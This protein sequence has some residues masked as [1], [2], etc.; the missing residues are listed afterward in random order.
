M[1][2][3]YRKVLVIGATSGIG[4]ALATKLVE[5]DVPV[6]VSGRRKEKLD[7]FVQKY[8][9]DGKK[10]QAKAFDILRI[11]RVSCPVVRLY[12]GRSGVREHDK[13]DG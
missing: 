3:D 6:I 10:V 2:F 12:P 4:H 9:A 5:H 13:H 8:G 7:E 11:N 1:S